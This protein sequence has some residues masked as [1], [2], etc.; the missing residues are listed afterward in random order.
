MVGLFSADDYA[1]AEQ[2]HETGAAKKLP[3]QK[4]AIKKAAD[5][6]I[7]VSAASILTYSVA[8]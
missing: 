8:L 1:L 3:Y 7:A 6:G 2:W 4:V 5:T